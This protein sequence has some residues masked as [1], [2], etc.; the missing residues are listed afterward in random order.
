VPTTTYLTAHSID[1]EKGTELVEREEGE[2]TAEEKWSL[3][4]Q[5]RVTGSVIRYAFNRETR[6]E[7]VRRLTGGIVLHGGELPKIR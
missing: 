2:T 3:V 1:V 4:F 7:L 6:D 5:D